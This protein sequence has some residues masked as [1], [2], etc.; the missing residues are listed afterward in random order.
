MTYRSNTS[1]F[2]FLLII[3]I[4]I[5]CDGN[6]PNVDYPRLYTF[7]S[8]EINDYHEYLLNGGSSFTELSPAPHQA[9]SEAFNIEAIMQDPTYIEEFELLNE[10]E[11]RIKLII[12]NNTTHDSTYQYSMN[13]QIIQVADFADF[14]SHFLAYDESNDKFYTRYDVHAALVGSG[15]PNPTPGVYGTFFL[16]GSN[17]ETTANLVDFL[18]DENQ[19]V[20]SDTLI[21]LIP[22]RVYE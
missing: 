17:F 3:T 10:K 7:N 1:I 20:S 6:E 14:G 19:Y 13:G 11:V 2:F 5:S 21:A 16:S 12:D 22:R 4:L 8:I 9:E 18:L 15:N